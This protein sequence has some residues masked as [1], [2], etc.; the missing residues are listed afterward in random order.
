MDMKSKQKLLYQKEEQ[1]RNL[2]LEI[3]TLK[4]IRLNEL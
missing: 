3:D 4:K 1:I 2:T